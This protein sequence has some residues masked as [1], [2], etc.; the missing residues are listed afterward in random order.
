MQPGVPVF[1]GIDPNPSGDG[2][3][4]MHGLMATLGGLYRKAAWADW[5]HRYGVNRPVP[6]ETI[7]GVSGYIAKYPMTGVCHWDVL[8]CVQQ[9]LSSG[10]QSRRISA[11]VGRFEDGLC[12]T[13]FRLT[14]CV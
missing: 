9:V 5:Y 8:N 6:I 11:S 3:H 7:G 14:G 10:G 4:H 2:G 1:Y 13:H 12:I